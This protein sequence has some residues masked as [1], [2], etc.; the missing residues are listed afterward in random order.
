MY[1]YQDTK[2]SLASIV[3]AASPGSMKHSEESSNSSLSHPYAYRVTV[4]HRKGH[5]AIIP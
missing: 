1:F 3:T 4:I 2:T 5:Y